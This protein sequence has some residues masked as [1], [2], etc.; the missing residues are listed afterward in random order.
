[1]FEDYDIPDHIARVNSEVR[2][3]FG[4]LRGERERMAKAFML[5]FESID[6]TVAWAVFDP[7]AYQIIFKETG[8]DSDLLIEQTTRSRILNRICRQWPVLYYAQMLTNIGI[9]GTLDVGSDQH[10]YFT[11]DYKQSRKILSI[12]L[13]TR[14]PS[15]GT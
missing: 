1:M 8:G 13:P 15:Y 12:A 10:Y 6:L 11:E 2:T 14:Q 7:M 9:M 3:I 5:P 4:H